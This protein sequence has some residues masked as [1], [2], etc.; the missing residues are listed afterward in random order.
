M[1]GT[2]SPPMALAFGE[3]VTPPMLKFMRGNAFPGP[4]GSWVQIL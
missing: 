4:L 2:P 1:V 3:T